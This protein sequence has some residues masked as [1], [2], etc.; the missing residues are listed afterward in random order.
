MKRKGRSSLTICSGRKEGTGPGIRPPGVYF[1]LC[2]GLLCDLGHV[3][4]PLC[5]RGMVPTHPCRVLGDLQVE[6]GSLT[7]KLRQRPRVGLGTLAGWLLGACA[8]KSE[9]RTGDEQQDWPG[10]VHA[11]GMARSPVGSG[12]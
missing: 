7:P 10:K 8:C 1:W 12:R 3:S 9:R 2:R 4:T 5:D 11:T 6:N